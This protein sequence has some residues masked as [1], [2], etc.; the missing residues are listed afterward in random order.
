[1]APEQFVVDL[2]DFIEH[3]LCPGIGGH[4]LAGLH[5]LL[6]G[7]EQK[8]LHLAFGE[9]A[10]EVEKRAMPG[11]GG[12]AA[13]LGLAALKIAFDDGGV[14]E[15]RGKGKGAQQMRLALAQGQSGPAVE[16][17][18]TTHIYV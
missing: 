14:Q 2:A 7:F 8:R 16:G 11:A 3:L 15:V 9:T 13:A 17:L 10:V 4:T 12:M 5:D 1:M 18:H 6:R